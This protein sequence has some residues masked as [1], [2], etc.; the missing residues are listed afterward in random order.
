MKVSEFKKYMQFGLGRCFIA[1]SG[2]QNREKYRKTVLYGCL[3]RLTYDEQSEGTR[4]EFIYSLCSLY[5]DSKYFCNAII[6]KIENISAANTDFNHLCDL[7]CEFAKGGN[8]EARLELESKYTILYAALLTPRKIKRYDFERDAFERLANCLVAIDGLPAFLNCAKDMGNL[9]SVN[10]N[11]DGW[12]FE[13]FYESFCD[14]F[15]KAET[16]GLLSEEAKN[17]A[18]IKKFFADMQAV[19]EMAERRND[20]PADHV[21]AA[22][23]IYNLFES[24]KAERIDFWRFGRLAD[25]GQKRILAEKLVH[26]SDEDKQAALLQ[27][28][29]RRGFPRGVGGLADF[30]KNA[31]R[32]LR[33]ALIEVFEETKDPQVHDIAVNFIKTDEEFLA[34]VKMLILNYTQADELLLLAALK[35]LQ[36]GKADKDDL[37]GI[38]MKI[39]DGFEEG[40]S[41][42]KEALKFVYENSFCACCRKEAVKAMVKLGWLTDEIKAE[43]AYDS[44]RDIRKIIG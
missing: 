9:F 26:E 41:L 42:P 4:A 25:D 7:L 20:R 14:R 31:N 18:A 10:S 40:I 16:E 43:C 19:R 39:T 1:L 30:L 33:A 35:K 32:N 27:A 37:H 28:F 34:G 15:G 2:C 23:E 8:E 3:H 17:S 44:N 13:W 12:D 38:F 22:E 6:R 21:P 29:S 11:Y 5:D 36:A 24:G